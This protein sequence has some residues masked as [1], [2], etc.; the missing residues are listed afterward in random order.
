MKYFSK[1]KKLLICISLTVISLPL[2]S[3]CSEEPKPQIKELLVYCG[4]TMVQ[5][6]VEIAKIIE[7]QEKCH[8]EILKGGS[9]HLYEVIT[10]NRIGDIF[11]PGSASYMEKAQREK[12][13]KD[14]VVVGYNQAVL[15]VQKDNPLKITPELCNLTDPRYAV[16]IA[17]P[18]SCS[19]GRLSK[20]LLETLNLYQS[21]LDNAVYMTTDSKDLIKAIKER[22]ADLALNWQAPASWPENR[23]AVTI[24]PLDKKLATRRALILGR[25]KFSKHPEIVKK[26]MQ[27]AVSPEGQAIFKRYGLH[28]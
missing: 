18:K 1:I 27:L 16:V 11:M 20:Q 9:G 19:I 4:I 2:F 15:M 26:F 8:F 13:V 22:K 5:P 25:L 7:I 24:L 6:M 3:G 23:E 21:T 17:N 10:S 12:I 28:D 14:T